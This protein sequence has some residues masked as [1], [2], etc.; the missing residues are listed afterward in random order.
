MRQNALGGLAL[1]TADGIFELQTLLGDFGG[2][3]RRIEGLQ[4]RDERRA[5]L[6]IDRAA[7]LAGRFREGTDRPFEDRMIIRHHQPLRHQP[8]GSSRRDRYR[9]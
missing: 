5:S 1:D 3:E 8:R 4:L 2:A 9:T 7:R 6:L